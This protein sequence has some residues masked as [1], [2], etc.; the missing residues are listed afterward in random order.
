MGPARV[1]L[2]GPSGRHGRASVD[3][4]PAASEGGVG[5]RL[6]HEQAVDARHRDQVRRRPASESRQRGVRVELRQ[7]IDRASDEQHVGDLVDEARVVEQGD[8]DERAV[9]G[10]GTQRRHEG[11][12]APCQRRVG[13]QRPFRLAGRPRREGDEGGRVRWWRGGIFPGGQGPHR[14]GSGA[15]SRA[16]T[17][18]PPAD[19]RAADETPLSR[20]RASGR[21]RRS[22]GRTSSLPSRVLSGTI[23]APALSPARKATTHS[24]QFSAMR[25]MR[26]AS[27]AP[28][29]ASRRASPSVSDSSSA[30]E[31]SSSALAQREGVGRRTRPTR[32]ALRAPSRGRPPRRR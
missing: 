1:E 31:S 22:G 2:L 27:A 9:A 25:T 17:A 15:R 12:G 28:A 4:D 10:V 7:E 8:H 26:C 23:T 14:G 29:A 16:R 21:R 6:E 3:G 24:T 5:L 32:P 20:G 18:R 11:P 19:A 13:Y 30:Y